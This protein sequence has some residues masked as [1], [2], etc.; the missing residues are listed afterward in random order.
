MNIKLE[1]FES[2]FNEELLLQGDLLYEH[3]QILSLKE[4]EK[5][6]WIAKVNDG[7][8]YEVEVLISPSKIK[9]Y[10]CDCKFFLSNKKCEHIVAGLFALRKKKRSEKENKVEKVR[11]RSFPQKVRTK[12][13]LPL[14]TEQELK[15]FLQNY[16]PKDKKLSLSFKARFA[17]KI[18]IQDGKNKYLQILDEL[19][20]PV[21]GSVGQMRGEKV[22]LY[23]Q[24]GEEYLA[25]YG[26]LI[27]LN[28]YS[29]ALLILAALI[30]KT[31]YVCSYSSVFLDKLNVLNAKVHHEWWEYT[32]KIDVPE[33]IAEQ[34]GYSTELAGNSY[35]NFEDSGLDLYQFLFQYSGFIEDSILESL[36]FKILR[37]HKANLDCSY[38]ITAFFK[39]VVKIN[40]MAAFGSIDRLLASRPEFIT[41]T[42][43]R[44]NEE[45]DF[46]NMALFLDYLKVNELSENL[47]L[48]SYRIGVYIYNKDYTNAKETILS[49]FTEKRNL[50]VLYKIRL[51][52]K[53]AQ[54]SLIN[55]LEKQLLAIDR[56]NDLY[57]LYE[58]TDNQASIIKRLLKTPRILFLEKYAF[59]YW[60]DYEEELIIAHVKAF[61]D[62]LKL[63]VG[64]NNSDFIGNQIRKIRRNGSAA[65]AK[66]IKEEV[67]KSYA[68]RDSLKEVFRKV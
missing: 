27:S 23:T 7:K 62:Y 53:N 36:S 45:S 34:V 43:D 66:K 41:R 40:K 32:K 60:D 42:L 17:Q 25:Q 35:Y 22:S 46:E 51:L 57:L 28:L 15:V 31:S 50:R 44:F 11:V 37:N 29:E 47:D 4:L 38:L 2:H 65:A 58:V 39:L 49:E 14:V 33:L 67:Y 24:L 54:K 21:T 18:E 64:Y 16:L 63:H 61:K 6:L 26:D 68:S 10:S 8:E 13:L 56:E 19:I 30:K 20:K 5:H 59:N 1:S 52:P 9:K 55:A 12:D 48:S 3:K